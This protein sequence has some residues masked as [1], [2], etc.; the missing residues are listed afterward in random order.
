M[1]SVRPISQAILLFDPSTGHSA[2]EFGIAGVVGALG[3]ALVIIWVGII[4]LKGL[5]ITCR[6]SPTGGP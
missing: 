1:E 3:S 6:N 4:S 5:A 2:S